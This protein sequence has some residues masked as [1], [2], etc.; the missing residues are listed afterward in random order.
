[1]YLTLVEYSPSRMDSTL[2]S[3]PRLLRQLLFDCQFDSFHAAVDAKFVE[4]I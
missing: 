4:N 3:P 2:L 1:M